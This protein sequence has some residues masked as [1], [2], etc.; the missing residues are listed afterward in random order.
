M[1]VEKYSTQGFSFLRPSTAT[2]PGRLGR[3][4]P[5]AERRVIGI[6]RNET[7]MSECDTC[8]G[9]KK[10]YLKDAL[11]G[12]KTH[13]A[14]AGSRGGGKTERKCSACKIFTIFHKVKIT[15]SFLPSSVPVTHRSVRAW[16]VGSVVRCVLCRSLVRTREDVLQ[17]GHSGE[18]YYLVVCYYFRTIKRRYSEAFSSEIFS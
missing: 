18:I 11:A 10:R 14:A 3:K 2:R 4:G 16:F 1:T 6:N 17:Q 13:A 15:F 7:E 9:G 8:M 5:G 12:G